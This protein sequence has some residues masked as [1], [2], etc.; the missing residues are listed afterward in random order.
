MDNC[1][2]PLT[3][4]D[5]QPIFVGASCTVSILWLLHPKNS[6]LPLMWPA[7]GLWHCFL[8]GPSF[9]FYFLL[10][11]I[12]A[13]SN[14]PRPSENL[15]AWS[16]LPF[17]HPLEP[18]NLNLVLEAL[19]A[20]PFEPLHDVS[21]QD[22]QGCHLSF[23]EYLYQVLPSLYLGIPQCQH[24]LQSTLKCC[25]LFLECFPPTGTACSLPIVLCLPMT[26]MRIFFFLPNIKSF[27]CW[28]QWRTQI[29]PSVC[30]SLSCLLVV[31]QGLGHMLFLSSLPYCFLHKLISLVLVGG[32]W[33]A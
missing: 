25:G 22:V 29:L 14:L 26:F 10:C 5:V 18:W 9:P 1:F 21:L 20:S 3:T 23:G 24:M 13:H 7:T 31:P 11:L 4:N 12:L 19:Q 6:G 28:I 30:F 33:S 27:S 16:A 2:N 8:K 17:W 32:L 15:F